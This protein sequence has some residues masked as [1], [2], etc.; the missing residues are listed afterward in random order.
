MKFVA[1]IFLLGVLFMGCLFFLMAFA[2]RLGV[3]EQTKPDMLKISL[4]FAGV[5][6]TVFAVIWFFGHRN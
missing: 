5:A 1:V 2:D 4:R 6:T 3:S